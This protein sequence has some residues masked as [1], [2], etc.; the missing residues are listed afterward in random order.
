[1]AQFLKSDGAMTGV[2][3]SVLRRFIAVDDVT[4]AVVVEEKG[5]I[6]AAQSTQDDRVRPRTLRI[7]GRDI[8]IAGAVHQSAHDVVRAV[9]I[10]NRWRVH[11]SGNIAAF[12]RVLRGMSNNVSNLCPVNQILR[13]PD[14]KAREILER[15]VDE[16]IVGSHAA[17][18]RI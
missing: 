9:V 3:G 5:R 10:A 7:F 13:V 16:I 17:N 4:P 6:N 12:G 8:K 14:G 11:P 1:E 15:G 2:L 18:G